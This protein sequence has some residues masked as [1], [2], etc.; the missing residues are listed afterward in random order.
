M[1]KALGTRLQIARYVSVI[2]VLD[3]GMA[4]QPINQSRQPF[5]IVSRE[6]FRNKPISF[7][8]YC[9]FGTSYCA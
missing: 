4:C 9:K 6:L 7:R 2:E 3:Y 5:C 1:T 8:L